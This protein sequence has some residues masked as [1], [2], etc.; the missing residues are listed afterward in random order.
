[1]GEYLHNNHI[2]FGLIWFT[3]MSSKDDWKLLRRMIEQGK[4]SSRQDSSDLVGANKTCSNGLKTR[5]VNEVNIKMDTNN[6]KKID[7]NI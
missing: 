3:L 4:M 2:P 6:Y 7:W 5:H 1:M